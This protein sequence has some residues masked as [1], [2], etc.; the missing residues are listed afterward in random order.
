MNVLFVDGHVAKI[1]GQKAD[2][3]MPVWDT[4]GNAFWEDL[5]LPDSSENRSLWG[6]G[7]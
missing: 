3:V 5:S 2:P 4:G 7:Y 6:P 1:K